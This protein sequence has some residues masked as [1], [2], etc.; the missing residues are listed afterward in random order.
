MYGL[1]ETALCC[2]FIDSGT[3]MVYSNCCCTGTMSLVFPRSIAKEN[4][5]KWRMWVI[6][7]KN[8]CESKIK[9]EYLL[10]DRYKILGFES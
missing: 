2:L 5:S 4:Y 8:T 6:K 10:L 3:Y 1:W 7:G 9:T